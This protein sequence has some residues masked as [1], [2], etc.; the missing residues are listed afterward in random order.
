MKRGPG[1]IPPKQIGQEAERD[2]SH[3]GP[4]VGKEDGPAPGSQVQRVNVCI[5]MSFWSSDF[6]EAVGWL[7]PGSVF[8]VASGINAFQ[9]TLFLLPGLSTV[10][11]RGLHFCLSATRLHSVIGRDKAVGLGMRAAA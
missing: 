9:G 10:Q 1:P 5:P 3:L 4:R 11:A 6:Q 7:L 8:L 2:F